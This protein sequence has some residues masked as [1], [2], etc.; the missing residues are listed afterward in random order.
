M[1][2]LMTQWTHHAPQQAIVS[3]GCGDGAAANWQ[4][5]KWEGPLIRD[6]TINVANT[7]IWCHILYVVFF[8]TDL[9]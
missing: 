4:L 9:S 5:R 1:Y 3:L 6:T 7:S 8:L 2:I